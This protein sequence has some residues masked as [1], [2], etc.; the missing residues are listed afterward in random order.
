MKVLTVLFGFVT[1]YLWNIL[2]ITSSIISL[3]VFPSVI[4]IYFSFLSG[5]TIPYYFAVL[6]MSRKI[7]LIF[8]THIEE[9]VYNNELA[10][11]SMEAGGHS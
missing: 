3:P 8:C 5:L 7:K 11:T 1:F 4:S 2:E 6:E 10:H 9:E